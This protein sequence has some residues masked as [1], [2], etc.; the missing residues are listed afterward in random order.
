MKYTKDKEQLYAFISSGLCVDV[1]DVVEDAEILKLCVHVQD[2]GWWWSKSRGLFLRIFDV[3]ERDKVGSPS[4]VSLRPELCVGYWRFSLHVM[5]PPVSFG[6]GM[7]WVALS[8]DEQKFLGAKVRERSNDK[9]RVSVSGGLYRLVGKR[10]VPQEFAT[11]WE[12]CFFL[13][14][15]L[16][17]DVFDALGRATPN[18]WRSIW[19]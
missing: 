12:A 8:P 5:E 17:A 10:W 7:L 6:F 14:W 15:V 1:W 9:F 18:L 11:T 13:R 4:V 16:G 19:L 3:K 2:V